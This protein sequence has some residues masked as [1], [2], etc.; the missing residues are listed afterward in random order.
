MTAGYIVYN[1]YWEQGCMPTKAKSVAISG[2]PDP[3]F[4]NGVAFIYDTRKEA[5]RAISRA[6][7]AGYFRTRDDW[8]IIRVVE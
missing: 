7:K 8:Q 6:M 5:H 3:K 4:T 1:R 2:F